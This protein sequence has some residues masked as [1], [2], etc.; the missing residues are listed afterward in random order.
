[1]LLGMENIVTMDRF[2]RLVLPRQ[3][4][5]A[6]HVRESTAFKAEV[7]GNRVELTPVPFKRGSI[8]KKR[9]GLLVLSTGGEKFDAADAVRAMRDERL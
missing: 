6:L 9:K 5:K 7:I 3:I 1:M 4:R 2:G 8:I